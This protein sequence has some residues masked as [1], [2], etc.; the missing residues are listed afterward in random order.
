[1]LLPLWSLLKF[2]SL[3][4]SILYQNVR[5][6]DERFPASITA[7]FKFKCRPSPCKCDAEMLL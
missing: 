1:M 4:E 7:R 3:L 5:V 2:V 6:L